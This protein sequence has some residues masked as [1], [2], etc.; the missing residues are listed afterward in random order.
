MNIDYIIGV[1][2]AISSSK[3]RRLC[4]KRKRAE[5]A[6]TVTEVEPANAEATVSLAPPGKF[7]AFEAL[8]RIRRLLRPARS[9]EVKAAAPPD[10]TGTS[11]A[12]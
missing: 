11:Q 12:R 3:A 6:S 7:E 9:D 8:S 1:S 10:T 2:N 5:S 4:T